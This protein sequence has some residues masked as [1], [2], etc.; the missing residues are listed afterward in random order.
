MYCTYIYLLYVNHLLEE[1]V[2]YMY[3]L[4]QMLWNYTNVQYFNLL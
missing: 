3:K 2:T 4:L 1:Y